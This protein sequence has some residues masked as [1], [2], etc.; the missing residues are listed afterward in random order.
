MYAPLA[1][2][3]YYE[4]SAPPDGPRPATDLPAVGPAARRRGRPRA[5]PTFTPESIEKGGARLY[6]DSL[7]MPTP[8]T[9]GMTS[10]PDLKTGFGVGHPPDGWMATRCNP[11]HIRQV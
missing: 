2:S 11:A 5:V 10:P 3:D 4:T 9:F 7:A 1:R 6:P 8:Q